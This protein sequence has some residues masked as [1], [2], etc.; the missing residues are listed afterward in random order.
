MDETT[1][2]FVKKKITLPAKV[3]GKIDLHALSG[4]E[5]EMLIKEVL[6]KEGY[7]D[8]VI[9][10][11]PSDKGV[12][13]EAKINDSKI[14]FQCKNWRHNV[15]STPIQRLHSYQIVRNK[16][17]AICITTSDFTQDGKIEAKKTEVELIDDRQI[18]RMIERH[19]ARKYY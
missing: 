6:M 9:T 5:F 7:K 18:R 4:K 10:G 2:G 16:D 17:K 13:I 8:V 12:D 1:K 11:S 19:F 14:I 3:K 15:G